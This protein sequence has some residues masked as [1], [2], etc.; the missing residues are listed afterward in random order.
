M[1]V[2]VQKVVTA[3]ADPWPPFVDPENPKE[4]LSMEI[5]KEAFKTQGY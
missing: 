5:V 3:A 1:S 4:G 2:N